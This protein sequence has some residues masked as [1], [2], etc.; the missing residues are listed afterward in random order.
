MHSKTRKKKVWMSGFCFPFLD[1]PKHPFSE[2]NSFGDFTHNRPNFNLHPSS[3][4]GARKDPEI[5]NLKGSIDH[6]ISLDAE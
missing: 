2:K 1:T 6:D 3:R 5:Q 4:G